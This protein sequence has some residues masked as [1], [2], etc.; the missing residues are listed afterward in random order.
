M[1]Y[2]FEVFVWCFLPR[3]RQDGMYLRKENIQYWCSM[4]KKMRRHER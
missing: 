1:V 2:I 4:K 3:H